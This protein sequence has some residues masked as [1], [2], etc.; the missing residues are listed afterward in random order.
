MFEKEMEMMKK[1]LKEV[2]EGSH[3]IAYELLQDCQKTKI[4][5][6]ILLFFTICLLFAS[7]IYWIN[8][9]KDLE[10][11]DTYEEIIQEQENTTNSYM[12]GEIN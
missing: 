7:N 6:I 1:T 8:Y 12:R 3:S 11:T 4:I 10:I 5:L 2:E 9:I